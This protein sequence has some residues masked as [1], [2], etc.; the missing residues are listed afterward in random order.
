MKS[1]LLKKG[2]PH[3]DSFF[4]FSLKSKGPTVTYTP[5]LKD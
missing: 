2:I 4:L 3:S 5:T 1:I